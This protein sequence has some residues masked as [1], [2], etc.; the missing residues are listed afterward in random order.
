VSDTAFPTTLWRIRFLDHFSPSFGKSPIGLI[1]GAP[2]PVHDFICFFQILNLIWIECGSYQI[3]PR[4]RAPFGFEGGIGLGGFGFSPSWGCKPSKYSL[5]RQGSCWFHSLPRLP[6]RIC[7]S[8][9]PRF[10]CVFRS[11]VVGEKTLLFFG[12]LRNCAPSPY[13]WPLGWSS[14]AK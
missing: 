9:A 12:R 3:D 8:F 2:T 4:S 14:I 5:F 6:R 7:L 10:F 1:A 13:S 11:P